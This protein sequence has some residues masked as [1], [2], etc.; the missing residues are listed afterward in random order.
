MGVLDTEESAVDPLAPA[1]AV[2]M[3]VVVVPLKA[4]CGVELPGVPLLLTIRPTDVSAVVYNTNRNPD[5]VS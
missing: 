5:T 1:V 4:D 3:G 2:K